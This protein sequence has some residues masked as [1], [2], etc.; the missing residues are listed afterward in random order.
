M[1]DVAGA[2]GALGI[3]LQAVTRS[4]QAINDGRI[5][6][7]RVSVLQR[8]TMPRA[9][10]AGSSPRPVILSALLRRSYNP[11]VCPSFPVPASARTKSSPKSGWAV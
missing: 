1:T 4:A 7:I 11:Q 8:R 10:P 6:R 5:R 9:T 2:E 3:P